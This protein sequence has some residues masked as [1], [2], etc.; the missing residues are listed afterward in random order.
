MSTTP[1]AGAV[2]L[3]IEVDELAR[4]RETA[5]PHAVLDVREPW[6][7]EL[8]RIADSIELPMGELSGRL[9][10]VPR[11]RPVVVLC[12]HGMRSLKATVWL[13]S[14]GIGQAINLAGGI[15]AWAR[16]IDRAM[17]VY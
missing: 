14:Q 10:E 16:R 3:Q 4:W 8:C 9:E 12:H 11:D 5:S 1:A 7:V 15:D 17:P 13:R 2:P 6:E